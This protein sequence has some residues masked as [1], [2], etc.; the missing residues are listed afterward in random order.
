MFHLFH[1]HKRQVEQTVEQKLSSKFNV[2]AIVF[3]P[4]H[5]FHLKITIAGT[6]ATFSMHTRNVRPSWN[7]MEGYL[8]M[9]PRPKRGWTFTVR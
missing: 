3:H 1:L 8:V 7:M 6:K 4:F 5:P 2:M 9:K